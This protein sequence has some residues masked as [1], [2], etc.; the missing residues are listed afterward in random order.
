MKEIHGFETGRI[1]A[2]NPNVGARFHRMA[3]KENIMQFFANTIFSE[4][5]LQEND[6][7]QRKFANAEARLTPTHLP[8]DIHVNDPAAGVSP[9]Q[10]SFVSRISANKTNSVQHSISLL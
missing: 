8:R 3:S 9:P 1:N 6:N 7:L 4:K 2:K 5:L 10:E